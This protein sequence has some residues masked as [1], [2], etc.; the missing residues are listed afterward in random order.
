MNRLTA[1]TLAAPLLLLG[2]CNMTDN[3]NGS[4]TISV[5]ENKIEQGTEFVANQ[6]SEAGETAVNA[7][8]NAGPELQNTASDIKERAGRV[9]DKV[10]PAV[11]N[12]AS[13]IEKGAG[14]V[15]DKAK[16]VDVDVDVKSDNK[17]VPK[18]K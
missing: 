10:G 2:A 16:N 18:A 12:T 13:K 7:V 15:A 4:S 3:G 11:E 6:A 1:A 17:P 9:A 14:N 8:E 5:D